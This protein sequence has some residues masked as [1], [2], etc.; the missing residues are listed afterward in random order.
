MP[1][2]HF[3]PS[4]SSFTFLPLSVDVPGMGNTVGVAVSL[5]LRCAKRRCD[6]PASDSS[7]SRL[8]VVP[9]GINVFHWSALSPVIDVPSRMLLLYL[10][11]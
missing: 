2:P 1:E 7:A 11:D 4:L 5:F 8:S 10:I 9:L 6:Q 3:I